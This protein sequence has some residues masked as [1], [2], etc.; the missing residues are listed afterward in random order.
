[1]GRR[2]KGERILGPY[3]HGS[4]WRVIEIAGTGERVGTTF[5]SKGQAE[6]F[7]KLREAQIVADDQ[8]TDSAFEAYEGHLKRKGNS[9]ESIK[10]TSWAVLR[11]FP[12]PLPLWGLSSK[13]C[14]QLY[15]DLTGVLAVDSHRNA[16]AEVKTFL[17]WCV[18]Q[19]WLS[20]NPAASIKGIGKRKKGKAQLRLKDTRVW[21][22]KA[23]E[24]ADDGDDGAIAALMALVLGMR[25]SEITLRR[26][27]DLDEDEHPCDLLVIDEGKTEESARTIE[28]PDPLRGFLKAQCEG[29]SRDSYLF[30][31]S[32]G[33]A[34]HHERGWVRDQVHRICELAKV[35][36][37]SAHAM[38]GTLG[39]I[40]M[41][42]GTASHVVVS[43]LGH[44]DIRTT[45][46]S[47]ARPGSAA[48]GVR[49]RGMKVLDGG[50][51]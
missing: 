34:G 12:E 49:R 28:V 13:K 50:K 9:S 24:L 44:A 21:Y 29:K 17:N 20:R 15:D 43:T 33:K 40:A 48:V 3:Q 18:E 31:T 47:Y 22:A 8:T 41:S 26:V 5:A 36:K 7:K 23:V 11:F 27:R 35:D 51:R 2:S 39:T 14:Q 6:R 37:V 46:Q 16:L 25:A 32:K 10:R 19:H 30:P 42:R 4:G 38:R 45:E 1:M